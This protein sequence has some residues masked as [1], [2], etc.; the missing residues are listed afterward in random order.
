MNEAQK[1]LL[2]RLKEPPETIEDV[3]ELSVKRYF[4]DVDGT[5][6]DKNT[7]PAVLQTAYPYFLFSQ[8]DQNGGY[9]ISLEQAPTKPGTHFLRWFVKDSDYNFIQFSGLN[10]V[11]KEINRGDLV[12]QFADDVENPNFFVFVVLQADKRSIA[13]I[14]KNNPSEYTLKNFKIFGDNEEVFRMGIKKI[15]ANR[16]GIYSSDTISVSS[17]KTPDYE[18]DGFIKVPLSGRLN[19]YL[20]LVS[21]I[22][23]SADEINYT[24]S[25]KKC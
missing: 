17:Y 18:T 20:G 19:P 23:F 22:P 7:V 3:I 5:I 2:Q 8:F 10:D 11:H 13:S 21:Y 1:I 6:V 16:M 24:I 9:R 12:F 15:Q 14:F 25:I 4:T